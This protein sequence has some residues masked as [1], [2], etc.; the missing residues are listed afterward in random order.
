MPVKSRVDRFGGL[1]D[2]QVPVNLTR[3]ESPDLRNVEF[4]EGVMQKRK[5][6]RRMHASS[7]TDCSIRLNGDDQ[8]VKISDRTT[9]DIYEPNNRLFLT[10]DVVLRKTLAD[11]RF[12]VSRGHS[13]AAANR[14]LQIS[15]DPSTPGWKLYVYDTST[16][17]GTL[18][19]STITDGTGDGSDIVGKYRH[20]EV[21][22]STGTTYKFRALDSAGSVVGSEQTFTQAG[23]QTD[24]NLGSATGYMLGARA[25]S[26]FSP[27]ASTYFPGTLAEFRVWDHT[28]APTYFS[29]A[30]A[31]RVGRELD[32]SPQA[33]DT[34]EYSNLT[35]Y[36]KLNDGTTST[37]T[38]Y[39]AVQNDGVIA[40]PPRWIS[41]PTLHPGPSA[42]EFYGEQGAVLWKCGSLA[43]NTFDIDSGTGL[44][45]LRTWT[46][47]FTF[48]P[49]MDKGE[50]TVRDQTLLWFGS[51]A[52]TPAPFG[53]EIASDK[54]VVKYR[55]NTS[56][57]T[58]TVNYAL[59]LKEDKP[60]RL[61]ALHSDDGGVQTILTSLLYDEN[62]AY[63][64]HV[65]V[66]TADSTFS[67]LSAALGIG[68]KFS[69]D[70]N[71][72]LTYHAAAARAVISDIWFGHTL[73]SG[74]GYHHGPM[75]AS[76]PGEGNHP[77][78]PLTSGDPVTLIGQTGAPQQAVMLGGLPMDEGEGEKLRV[79]GTTQG[80]AQYA[81]VLPGEEAGC[82]WD[83]GLVE[84]FDPPEIDGI[85]DYRRVGKD[86]SMVRSLLVLSGTTLYEARNLAK[87]VG[88]ADMYPVAGNIH[89]GGKAT[90]TQ[91]GSTVYIGRENGFRPRKYDGRYLDWVGI[92]APL[93]APSAS[94]DNHASGS[95]PDG[96]YYIYCTY[97]NAETG[98]ESNPSPG[99]P[100]TIS[101][102]D[103]AVGS[104][105]LPVSTDPQVNRRRIYISTA[106]ATENAAPIYL[107]VTVED[108][109]ST[110]YA[111]G[112]YTFPDTT[113]AVSIAD[114]N[115]N[116]EA[117]AGSLVKSFKDRLWVSGSPL[118]P[119]RVHYSGVL[120]PDSFDGTAYLGL[121]QD[122]GDKITGFARLLNRMVVM[123]RDGKVQLTASGLS[124]TPFSVQ[125]VSRD[126]GAVGPQAVTEFDGIL[127]YLGERDVNLWDGGQPLNISSPNSA[128]RP[129][130]QDTVRTA[131][132]RS[133]LSSAALQINRTRRQV[134]LSAT[135][136]GDT[137]NTMQ[138]VFDLETGT[139]SRYSGMDIDAMS[140]V[141][142][143]NDDVDL[144]AG[145]RGYLC[146][147]DEGDFD[148]LADVVFGVATGGSDDT[149][150]DT[151]ASFSTT[152]L[153][154]LYLYWYDISADVMRSSR[155]R[156][157][158]S[159]T[160]YLYDNKDG[161]EPAA[162]DI[163]VV[164]GIQWYADFVAD[165]GNPMMAK[166][167]HWL[168]LAGSSSLD[169]NR[170]RVQVAAEKP[171][172]DSAWN[173]A[174]TEY[175]DT[176]TASETYKLIGVGGLGRS[177]RV[178][179]SDTGY[180]SASS[181]DAVPMGGRIEVY[182]WELEGEE[183]DLQ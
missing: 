130:I 146:K 120:T 38:D 40:D 14:F 143:G 178:R 161:V 154:G 132:Q 91:L 57:K 36:W 45:P 95:I 59:S 104:I 168:R 48:V 90:F 106:G 175:I 58:A 81:V 136:S 138:L 148:G 182:E 122:T 102:S 133:R 153:K 24:S 4:S 80:D 177:F 26:A 140:E 3:I 147:V 150:V 11:E 99:H 155:I 141:E 173:A 128:D 71:E 79:V 77:L 126:H 121:D 164:G 124:D 31:S 34:D 28:S 54:V 131:L 35:G 149:L 2:R 19:T 166:K 105:N 6:Y 61:V 157:S 39:S 89:K 169:G 30:A 15:Y 17:G 113:T 88:N 60:L 16:G 9:S 5:G 74:T 12:V 85:F 72:P 101:G 125:V 170:I 172:R 84:P 42:L 163:Y 144:Y 111:A 27:V 18:V 135:P 65:N 162:G 98:T 49:R 123:M 174:A 53:V 176:W 152:A 10:I 64:A 103:D 7:M 67:T 107:A 100:V 96:T 43:N 22:W 55:D 112:I 145:I 116:T 127:A 180:A 13:G 46:V 56:L 66:S 78:F 93:T 117:P 114:F 86:G 70:F 50:T 110:S 83:V 82:R 129:S 63:L 1:S 158:T 134:W 23:W 75:F 137:R 94:A 47:A 37:V 68:R 109:V 73:G 44:Y 32:E 69:T 87:G 159:T 8:Y 142:D 33:G 181:A 29:D 20:L 52:T 118:T 171:A 165:F 115:V 139:W 21:V 97:V 41:D 156:K 108:N 76:G 51:D 167:I 62:G 160:L 25:D 119:N 151:A 183:I 92:K 179:I